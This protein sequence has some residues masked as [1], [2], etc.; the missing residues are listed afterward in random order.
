MNNVVFKKTAENVRKHRDIKLIAT[1][2]DRK[3]LVSEPSYH[4]ANFFF[5]KRIINR[6]EKNTNIHE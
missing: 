1:K 3:Y 5:W 6:N 2:A 4:T